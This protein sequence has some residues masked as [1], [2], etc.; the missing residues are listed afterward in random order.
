MGAGLWVGTVTVLL[1]PGPSLGH[2]GLVV[3][4]RG[5]SQ[6]L[7]EKG[8]GADGDQEEEGGRH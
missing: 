6:I 2:L 5:L 4:K 8:T 1:D 3:F 7:G